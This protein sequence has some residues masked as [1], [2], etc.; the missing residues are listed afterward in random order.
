MSVAKKYAKL[1]RK[2]DLGDALYYPSV[3][4][5]V[6]D[7][8]Y[9]RGSTYHLVMNVLEISPEVLPSICEV[10]TLQTAA[11]ADA[12]GIQLPG[13]GD[14]STP[15]P[16]QCQTFTST[17]VTVTDMQGKIATELPAASEFQLLV[18]KSKSD[19]CVAVCI[20]SK[21]LDVI[22]IRG[23][24][25]DWQLENWWAESRHNIAAYLG[26]T[27]SREVGAIFLVLER[28]VTDQVTNCFYSGKESSTLL[29]IVGKMANLPHV[30]I[31]SGFSCNEIGCFGFTNKT[32]LL[33]GRK[34][35]IFI[36]DSKLTAFAFTK[37]KHIPVWVW[38]YFRY[39]KLLITSKLSQNKKPNKHPKWRTF[40]KEKT[41]RSA[42]RPA[43]RNTPQTQRPGYQDMSL[44]SY[45]ISNNFMLIRTPDDEYYGEFYGYDL[46]DELEDTGTLNVKSN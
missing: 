43:S 1:L 30:S 6:G 15:V 22:A 28:T 44:E 26:P 45:E 5:K 46:P 3:D 34:W 10:D 33:N 13:F 31:D 9:F 20:P 7:V 18:K 19:S 24:F 16:Y 4:V 41:G 36:R 40:G 42:D 21:P 37:W 11:L 2:A 25:Q 12:M 8:A 14:V 17:V 38:Q 35:T 29:R 39:S 32:P 23:Q 27:L